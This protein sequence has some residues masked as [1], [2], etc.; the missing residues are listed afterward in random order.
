VLIRLAVRIGIALACVGGVVV[1]LI[2]R[3]SRTTEQKA[4]AVYI[5]TKDAQQTLKLLDDAKPLNPDFAIAVGE[6]RLTKGQGVAILREAVE[7]EPENAELWVRLAQQQV[8]AG[9]RAG[10]QRS[11]ARARELA[12]L[13]PPDG[14][15]PGV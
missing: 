6:A 4:F 2:A 14:P 13:L 15:P 10:A 12:P 11:Y 5:D 1:S 8:A 9:D 3:D 7:R